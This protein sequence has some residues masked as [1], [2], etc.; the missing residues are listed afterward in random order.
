MGT[1]GSTSKGWF[2]LGLCLSPSYL[3][4][5]CLYL[6][7]LKPLAIQQTKRGCCQLKTIPRREGCVPC[8]LKAEE[9]VLAA[10]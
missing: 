7:Y 6:N 10:T 4:L 3:Y 8:D 1:F 2:E 9:K 5:N